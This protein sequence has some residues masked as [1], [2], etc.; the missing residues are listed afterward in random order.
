MGGDSHEGYEIFHDAVLWHVQG[1]SL[2]SNL[3][4]LPYYDSLRHLIIETD[5]MECVVVHLPKLGALRS[6]E[7]ESLGMRQPQNRY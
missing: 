1:L 7:L 3:P 6:L 2:T 4:S 5:R